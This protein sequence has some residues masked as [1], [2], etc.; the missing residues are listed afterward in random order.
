MSAEFSPQLNYHLKGGDGMGRGGES[1][2]MGKGGESEVMGRGGESEVMGE[3]GRVM[4]WE[5]RGE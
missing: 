1:E 5:R 3:E 2:V 4:G